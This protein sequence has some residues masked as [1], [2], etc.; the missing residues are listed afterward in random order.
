MK[1]RR[2]REESNSSARINLSAVPYAQNEYYEP[3]MLKRTDEAVVTDTVFPELTQGTVQP[4]ADLARIVEFFDAF[5]EEI[6]DATS[7]RR[8]EL[9]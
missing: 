5:I 6:E 1:W 7:D 2:W 8:V 3:I 9:L 4:L